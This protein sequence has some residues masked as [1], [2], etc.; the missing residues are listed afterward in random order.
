MKASE[1][2]TRLQQLIAEHG[3]LE[4]ARY[5]IDYWS[6]FTF[7][8]SDVDFHDMLDDRYDQRQPQNVFIGIGQ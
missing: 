5:D 3:D 6:Y 2:I 7:D 1:L 8:A 4:V